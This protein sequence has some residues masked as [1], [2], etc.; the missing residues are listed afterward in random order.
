LTTYDFLLVCHCNCSSD[1]EL[2]WAWNL[3]SGHTRSS[4]I[5]PFDILFLFLFHISNLYR[6]SVIQRRILAWSWNM[7]YGSFKV[8][9]NGADRYTT[10]YWS[11]CRCNYITV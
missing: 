9:E 6:Y 7:G 11:S 5:S 3:R 2:W 8:I 10:L 4:E 1:F